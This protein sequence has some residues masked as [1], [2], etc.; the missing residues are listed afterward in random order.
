MFT[1]TAKQLFSALGQ[2]AQPLV[3]GLANCEQP[4]SHRGPVNLSP[5]TRGNRDG[6]YSQ[7]PW[8]LQDA[9]LPPAGTGADLPSSPSPW[10]SYNTGF[11]FPTDQYFTQNQFFGGPTLHVAGDSYADNSV[12]Q[13]F[14]GETVNTTN[15]NVEVINQETVGG[16]PAPAGILGANGADGAAGAAGLPGAFGFGRFRQVE[17]LAPKRF[18]RPQLRLQ[19]RDVS[20]PFPDRYVDGGHYRPLLPY[21]L[22]TNAISGGTVSVAPTPTAISIPATGSVTVTPSP[23]SLSIPAAA[24]V[25]VTPASVALS[26]PSG[27]T[28][29]VTPASV[30]L[31]IPTGVTFNPDTCEVSFLG[32]QTVS[33]ASAASMTADVNIHS[34][35]QV[36]VGD[37][38]P[39]TGTVNIHQYSTVTVGGS[40][41][42]TGNLVIDSYSTATVASSS[43]VTASLNTVAAST[44]TI[45]A[46]SSVAAS[47]F[48]GPRDPIPANS[49]VIR[50]RDQPPPQARVV[51]GHADLVGVGVERRELLHRN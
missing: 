28:V 34:Y 3:Q 30:S 43:A 24:T 11:Y 14:E 40:S 20:G 10:N 18:L 44:I 25:S 47:A 45:N 38:V 49:V 21:D 48:A 36:V 13:T 4:L 8:S 1:S 23:V 15:L 19:K 42:M 29:S 33:V 5:A 39:V 31:V 9:P 16:P 51:V 12:A 2:G 46:F 27:M 26:I 50:L 22:P 41:P 35:A 7:N 32:Y 17:F 6:T 37:D